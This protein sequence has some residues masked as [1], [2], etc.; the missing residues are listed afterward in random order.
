MKN[1]SAGVYIA[2]LYSES[3]VITKKIIIQN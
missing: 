3:T 1:Y 2:K